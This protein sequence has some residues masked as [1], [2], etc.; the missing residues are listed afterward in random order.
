MP[1]NSSSPATVRSSQEPCWHYFSYLGLSWGHSAPLAAFWITV[2]RFLCVL[3]RSGLDFEVFW[4]HSG[5]PRALFFEVFQRIWMDVGL[6]FALAP[7]TQKP[8]KNTGFSMIFTYHACCAPN[9][10]TIK[11]AP[12]ACWT[13][14][15]TN[16][17]LE[18]GLGA[19][20]TRFW[21]GLG[22]SL[23]P[24]GRL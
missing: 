9:K 21:K 16:M 17:A 15:P 20:W 2:G 24:L 8:R 22:H 23:V 6:Y 7:N 19:R 12:G 1:P 4:G 5:S 13:K 3:D 10:K 18:P 14:L 11:I